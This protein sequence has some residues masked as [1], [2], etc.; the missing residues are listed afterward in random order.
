MCHFFF[1]KD[2]ENRGRA[3]LFFI[4]ITGQRARHR[5]L[6]AQY[7]R[8]MFEADYFPRKES[9][10]PIPQAYFRSDH[11]PSVNAQRK[12][13]I[14]VIDALDECGMTSAKMKLKIYLFSQTKKF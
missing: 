3:T 6:L 10:R 14:I 11:K 12:A 5:T 13:T 8:E 9:Q 4:I 2:K 7:V 1:K